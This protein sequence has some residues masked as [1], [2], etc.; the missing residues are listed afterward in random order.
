MVVGYKMKLN[1][2]RLIFIFAVLA[3]FVTTG[4]E[5][6]ASQSYEF[7]GDWHYTATENKV[8]EDIWVSFFADGTFEM[9]QKV[10]EGPYWYSHGEFAFDSSTDVLSG[11][12]SDRYDWKYSYN[13]SVSGSTMVMK[14]VELEN[15]SVTYTKETVPAEVKEKSLPL[16]KSESVERYL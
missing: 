9:Y 6:D 8:A 15:Y 10:G 13:V 1:M 7:L 16:T 2:K 4:C 3:L 5:K 12:Y 14:A 11:V